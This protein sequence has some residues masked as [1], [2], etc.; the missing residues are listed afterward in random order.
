MIGNFGNVTSSPDLSAHDPCG[1]VLSIYTVASSLHMAAGVN[2][3]CTFFYNV[4]DSHGNVE[5]YG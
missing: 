2:D 4:D 3:Q 5:N 1:K